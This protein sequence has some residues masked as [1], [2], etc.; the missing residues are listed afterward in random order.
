M[1]IV[2]ETSNPGESF[3]TKIINFLENFDKEVANN[4]KKI[5]SEFSVCIL[6]IYCNYF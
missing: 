5:N 2:K 3:E 6:F 4:F 1:V